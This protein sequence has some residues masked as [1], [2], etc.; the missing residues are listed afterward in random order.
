MVIGRRGKHNL[1]EIP[2]IVPAGIMNGLGAKTSLS[3]RGDLFLRG[4]DD[5]MRTFI[6][7]EMTKKGKK[8]DGM[9]KGDKVLFLGDQSDV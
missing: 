6:R 5:S 1:R 3:Y 8:E 9:K 2:H 4:F 7:D